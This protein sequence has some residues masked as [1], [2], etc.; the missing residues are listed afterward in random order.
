MKKLLGLLSLLVVVLASWIVASSFAPG[1]LGQLNVPQAPTDNVR[2]IQE[3]NAVID[4]VKSVGPSVVTVVERRQAQTR[5]RINVGPFGFNIE[6]EETTPEPRSIGTG[7]VVDNSGLIATN[8]HVVSDTTSTYQILTENDK[9]FD[10]EEVFRDPLNDIALLKVNPAQ[11]RDVSL[12]S[13]KLG[14]S[15]NL[16]VGQF[17][18]AIGTALGEFSNTVTTGVISGLGRG[19]TAGSAFQGFV[20]RLDDVIQTD[21]AINPGNSGGPLVNISG[22]VIGINTA[23]SQA[24]ENIGFALPVN[25]LK[26]ALSNFRQFGEFNRPF[27]GVSFR[28]LSEEEARVS[29]VVAG[30][31]VQSIVEGSP[32]QRAGLR[33]GDIITRF[34]GK[35]VLPGDNELSTLIATRKVGDSV[36]LVVWRDGETINITATLGS[37][38]TE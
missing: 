9:T 33:A 29:D 20:E 1:L 6:P 25:V 31:L 15:E 2:V 13:V 8:K 14:D 12:R 22:E 38:P 17:V 11:H 26:N 4:I 7:F 37:A 30:A 5:S 3:E 21:A 35:N 36:P 19:I 23:V 10:V 28:M 32:A 27:L 18:V 24:G 34:D 16:Q